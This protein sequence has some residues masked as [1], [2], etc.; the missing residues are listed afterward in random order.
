ML[1]DDFDSVPAK[2]GFDNPFPTFVLFASYRVPKDSIHVLQRP[3]FG[4]WYKDCDMLVRSVPL[5]AQGTH[6]T[7]KA[8]QAMSSPHR[9]QR[10]HTAP[11][12]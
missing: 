9:T 1:S 3:A 11:H 4:L 6:N 8:A 5:I 2:Q 7:S 10:T 12:H